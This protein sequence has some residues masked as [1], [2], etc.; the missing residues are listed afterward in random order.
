[1]ITPK[2]KEMILLWA[3]LRGIQDW[4]LLEDDKLE[5]MAREYFIDNS[6]AVRDFI[7]ELTKRNMLKH[8]YYVNKHD[9][10]IFTLLEFTKGNNSIVGKTVTREMGFALPFGLINLISRLK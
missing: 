9:N 1:M 10:I 2:E 6:N 4:N 3:K 5:N 8:N 7:M